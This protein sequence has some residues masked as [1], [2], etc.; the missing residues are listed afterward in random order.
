MRNGGDK[1]GSSADRARRKQWLLDAYGDGNTVPCWHCG[2]R[3]TKAA[4]E[5]DRVIPGGSYARH[6]IL[7]S[8]GPCNKRRGTKPLAMAA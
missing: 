4:L 1:R 7:P 3:L 2:D 6:N 5:A 8:C